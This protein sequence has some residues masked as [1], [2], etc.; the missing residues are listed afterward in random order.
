MNVA[1]AFVFYELLH[2]LGMN[3]LLWYYAELEMRKC[4]HLP[5]GSADF[6]NN[7]KACA[8]W[9]RFTK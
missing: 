7:E 6:D 9:R 8:I 4:Y 3:Q 2:A 1:Y 5:D